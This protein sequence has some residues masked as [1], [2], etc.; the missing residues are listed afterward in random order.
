[1]NSKIVLL[2]LFRCEII[3]PPF[4]HPQTRCPKREKEKL[5]DSRISQLA[6]NLDRRNCVGPE[7]HRALLP[8]RMVVRRPASRRDR[9]QRVRVGRVIAHTGIGTPCMHPLGRQRS[10]WQPCLSPRPAQLA[11]TMPE[12]PA[13]AAWRQLGKPMRLMGKGARTHALHHLARQSTQASSCTPA[14][15]PASTLSHLQRLWPIELEL[16]VGGGQHGSA[17]QAT[18]AV[19]MPAAATGPE[20]PARMRLRDKGGQRLVVL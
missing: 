4:S 2:Y 11:A 12:A 15:A 6:Q 14:A 17:P 8:I 1:M 18:M 5:A 19:T 3:P 20:A 9:S 13:H 16:H 10:R 7:K